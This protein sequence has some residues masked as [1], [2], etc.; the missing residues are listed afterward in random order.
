MNEYIQIKF[1]FQISFI[2]NVE[3]YIGMTNLNYIT[4]QVKSMLV[5][6]ELAGSIYFNIFDL[7]Y[8]IL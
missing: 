5:T 8:I 7:N 2:S 6:S 3:P 1:L 4:K